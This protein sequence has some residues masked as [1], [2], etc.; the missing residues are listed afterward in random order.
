VPHMQD[1]MAPSK[2]AGGAAGGDGY[3]NVRRNPPPPL[4]SLFPRPPTVPPP[5]M[6][7]YYATTA[8]FK[9]LKGPGSE[10]SPCSSNTNTVSSGGGKS[11]HSHSSSSCGQDHSGIYDDGIG[12]MNSKVTATMIN[13]Y[14]SGNSS[15]TSTA[16]AAAEFQRARTYNFRSYPDN[17]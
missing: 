15:S 14:S 3:V 6:E 1:F 13:P 2:M 17:L 9:P 10:R 8:I 4:S 12:T 16:A 5:P 11:S 7:K